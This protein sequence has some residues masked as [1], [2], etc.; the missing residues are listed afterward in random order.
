[1][2]EDV[3]HLNAGGE[4]L[5]A[6]WATMAWESGHFD[7]N[8]LAG[9]NETVNV[10]ERWRVIRWLNDEHHLDVLDELCGYTLTSDDRELT[11]ACMFMFV[12]S[13]LRAKSARESV[14]PQDWMDL[15]LGN[16]DE[17]ALL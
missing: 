7:W 3:L 5:T 15:S 14:T 10:T 11:A 13:G 6:R 8:L 12:T 2:Q 9:P 1:M 4:L 17:L 16:A